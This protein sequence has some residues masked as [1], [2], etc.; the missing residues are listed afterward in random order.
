MEFLYGAIVL[1]IGILV[2]FYLGKGSSLIPE[3][4]Q[5]QV[6]R[7]IQALPVKNDLGPVERPSAKM[8][9]DFNNPMKKAGDEA[10]SKTFSEIIKL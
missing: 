10:L 5:K 7:L 2:G 3:E 9:E 4:T 1:L 8:V 6:K